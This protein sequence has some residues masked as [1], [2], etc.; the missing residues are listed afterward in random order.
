MFNPIERG[1]QLRELR[2]YANRGSCGFSRFEDKSQKNQPYQGIGDNSPFAGNVRITADRL[3]DA[4]TGEKI[5]NVSAV[6]PQLMKASTSS[7]SA[8]PQIRK[9]RKG[10]WRR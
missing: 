9:N 8:N 5:R 3:V 4:P 2:E 10:K 1:K 7:L 6:H